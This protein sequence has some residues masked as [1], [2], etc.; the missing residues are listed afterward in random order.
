MSRVGCGASVQNH[1]DFA[2]LRHGT[3]QSVTIKGWYLNMWLHFH[4]SGDPAYGIIASVKS[5]QPDHEQVSSG[6]RAK[7]LSMPVENKD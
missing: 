2:I 6:L 1:R 4:R 7:L 5:G 3:L